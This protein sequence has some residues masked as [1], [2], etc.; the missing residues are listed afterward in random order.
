MLLCKKRGRTGDDRENFLGE[1]MKRELWSATKGK[2]DGY[3]GN[4]G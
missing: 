3:L 2:I 4:P 1:R